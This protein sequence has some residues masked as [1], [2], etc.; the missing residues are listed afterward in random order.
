[1]AGKQIMNWQTLENS[2][3]K[4]RFSGAGRNEEVY[5]AA[6]LSRRRPSGGDQLPLTMKLWRLLDGGLRRGFN[7]RLG[8]QHA[9]RA[10]DQAKADIGAD[11]QQRIEEQNANQPDS[12]EEGADMK[13]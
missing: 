2:P 6:E 12:Q 9:R 5:A 3:G 10:D 13:V 11:H 4:W 8:E 7:L 1:M